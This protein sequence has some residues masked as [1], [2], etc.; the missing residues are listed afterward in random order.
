MAAWNRAGTGLLLAGGLGLAVLMVS[1]LVG[2]GSSEPAGSSADNRQADPNVDEVA[3]FLERGDWDDFRRGIEAVVR[4]RRARLIESRD[5][6][7]V[8][9]TPIRRR[10]V[11]FSWTKTR[12]QIEARAEVRR[13]A[14]LSKPPLAIV[15]ASNTAITAALAEGLRD[16]KATVGDKH[17]SPALLIPLAT[18]VEV[19]SPIVLMKTADAR[20]K[21]LN[22]HAGRTFRF[23]LDNRRL[24]ESAVRC[25]FAREPERPPKR[26]S[27]VVDLHDPCSR[28]LALCFR[29]AVSGL[30]KTIAPEVVE[31]PLREEGPPAIDD[32]PRGDGID[33]PGPSERALAE[34]LCRESIEVPEHATAWVVLTLQRDPLLT[35][36]RAL[37]N[38]AWYHFSVNGETARLRVLA[39]DG[40]GLDILRDQA[41][42]QN[43]PFPFWL[44]SSGLGRATVG[45]PDDLTQ[46]PCEIVSAVIFCIDR[47]GDQTSADLV[48]ALRALNLPSD[49][50][51]S[52]GRPISFDSSGERLGSLGLVLEAQPGNDAPIVSYR[53]DADGKWIEDALPERHPNEQKIK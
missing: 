1:L 42:G 10:R 5:E 26:V 15:G 19:G 48:A 22:I 53:L 37:S 12:G 51:S 24:A 52:M 30:P 33:T 40:I 41:R 36:L 27:L 21:L 20:V 31:T 4:E 46:T 17:L 23:C 9:E 13:R 34:K 43:L 39:G 38:Q 3:V 49:S 7:I 32:V 8:L 45:N 6:A 44:V 29:A 35:M 28:D 25:L 16:A 47:A 50:P 11:R 2:N 18:A 14:E